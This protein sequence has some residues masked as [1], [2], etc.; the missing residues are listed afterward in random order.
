LVGACSGEGAAGG[1]G[2][3]AAGGCAGSAGAAGACS[4]AGAAGACSGVGAGCA[5]A[6]AGGGCAGA[7]ACANTSP[8]D[9]MML[10]KILRALHETKTDR[11]PKAIYWCLSGE[12]GMLRTRYGKGRKGSVGPSHFDSSRAH[13]AMR[14]VPLSRTCSYYTGQC[15]AGRLCGRKLD[16]NLPRQGHPAYEQACRVDD[17]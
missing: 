10:E 2:S 1:G 13:S 9:N 4:G 11:R 7:G 3:A 8:R 16:Q 6:G 12:H 5:G 14:Q 15:D 17:A